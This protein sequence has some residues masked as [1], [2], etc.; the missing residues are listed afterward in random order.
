[1]SE[2]CRG[3]RR[4]QASSSRSL[5]PQAGGQVTG[6][7][8]RLA[9]QPP[10][11]PAPPL[12]RSA[13]PFPPLRLRWQPPPGQVTPAPPL[14]LQWS[15]TPTASQSPPL[16]STL[17]AP[18]P[19]TAPTPLGTL[20]AAWVERAGQLCAALR[21]ESR[22]LLAARVRVVSA[23]AASAYILRRL[24]QAFCAMVSGFPSAVAL[25]VSAW[26]RAATYWQRN[27]IAGPTKTTP[28]L[29]YQPLFACHCKSQG[30][31]VACCN[32]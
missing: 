1:M 22:P 17:L 28:E 4:Q 32:Q 16:P 31:Q 24:G 23:L 25:A 15:L 14:L 6:S 11:S 3:M 21:A 13:K 29:S 27:R 26:K 20:K 5:G 19:A 9:R 12:Q 8:L 18:T 30:D 7:N 2:T 10:E